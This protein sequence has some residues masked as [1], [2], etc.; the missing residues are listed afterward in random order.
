M[1]NF[2]PGMTEKLILYL[3]DALS[4]ADKIELQKQL[5]ADAALQE[6]LDSLRNSREAVK[7][8]GLQQRVEK[9]HGEMMEELA[10]SVT[11]INTRKNTFRYVLAVAASLVLIIVGY[12]AYSFFTLSPDKVFSS[13]YKTFSLVTVRD[14]NDTETAAEKAYRAGNFKEVIRIHDDNEDHSAKAEFL[15]GAAAL[16]LKDNAKALTCFKEVLELNKISNIPILNDEA[17]Y[18]L[19]LSYLQNQDYDLALE[20]LQ[21]IR[22]TPDHLYNEKVTVKLIRQVKLLK[23]K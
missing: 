10:P 22:E 15:C 6:E 5:A 8:Y 17:E 19:S 12:L 2:T 16:E 18:Y 13:N 14:G 7:L 1:D 9:V 20:M 11:K 21:K 3:E 4:A 23:W